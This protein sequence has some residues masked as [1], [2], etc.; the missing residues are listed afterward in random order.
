MLVV[1]AEDED[2]EDQQYE[3]GPGEAD[4]QH[5]EEGRRKPDQVAE[6]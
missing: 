2:V 1:I 6:P 5:Q 3:E 4:D